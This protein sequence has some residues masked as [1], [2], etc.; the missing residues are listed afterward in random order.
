MRHSA[1]KTNQKFRKA[2]R[3]VVLQAL[4]QKSPYERGL[5]C[6]SHNPPRLM[7]VDEIVQRCQ[8]FLFYFNATSAVFTY[9]NTYPSVIRDGRQVFRVRHLL[10]VLLNLGHGG[11][12]SSCSFKTRNVPSS[13]S[14][15]LLTVNICCLAMQTG[16]RNAYF[17]MSSSL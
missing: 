16:G 17:L 1:F 12:I 3:P 9:L 15:I 11:D 8:H 4:Y 7:L 13:S 14:K 2:D 6:F 5:P 10:S